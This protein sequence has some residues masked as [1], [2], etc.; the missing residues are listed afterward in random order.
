MK[1]FTHPAQMEMAPVDLNRALRNTLIIARSEYKY[2]AELEIELGE[3]P[4]VTCRVNDINQVV[5]N[6][7][8]NAAQAIGDVVKGTESKGT[9]RVQTRQDGD[10]V[11]ISVADTGGGI[12]PGLESRIFEPFFTTKEVG[13]GTGQGLAIARS[14]VKEKHGGELTF[15]SAV[16]IGATFFVRLPIAGSQARQQVEN[17]AAEA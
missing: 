16:G 14:M 4:P 15:Q 11:L 3:I 1:E 6:L 12:P 9:I 13:K 8:V 7:V 10:D 2:V 5:L 17:V